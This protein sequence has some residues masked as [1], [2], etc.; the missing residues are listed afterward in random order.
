MR[1]GGFIFGTTI[2]I[3]MR[4]SGHHTAITITFSQLGHRLI[5]DR[6]PFQANRT[7]NNIG[8]PEIGIGKGFVI[9]AAGTAQTGTRTNRCGF[10]VFGHIVGTIQK[11]AV[12]V[13]TV[14]GVEGDRLIGGRQI[15]GILFVTFGVFGLP[16]RRKRE[17]FGKNVLQKMS[18][19]LVGSPRGLFGR[20]L[21][22][23]FLS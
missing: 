16:G 11:F 1:F 21:I 18:R 2:Q 23:A 3:T 8:W 7:G 20:R 5:S 15:L 4:R 22:K 13:V 14:L 10:I 19:G 9:H 12:Y 17:I 6:G